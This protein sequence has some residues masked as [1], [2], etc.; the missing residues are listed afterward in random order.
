MNA[1]LAAR[2]AAS[3][4]TAMEIDNIIPTI[5]NKLSIKPW[6]QKASIKSTRR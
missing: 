1:V 2:M 4:K 5:G 3:G 6:A